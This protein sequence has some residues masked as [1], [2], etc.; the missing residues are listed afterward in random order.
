MLLEEILKIEDENVREFM[1]L[2]F[3]DMVNANNMFCT[4]DRNYRKIGP[5]FGL[6]AYYPKNQPVENNVWG[7]K[8]GRGTFISY[9]DKTLR[10]KRYMLHPYEIMSKN[11]NSNKVIVGHN[12]KGCLDDDFRELLKGEANAILRAQ[13]SEDLSF[14]PDKS[15]DA[16]IT[17]PPYYDNVMY[18][19]ISDFFYVWQ[20]LALQD[21]HEC[22]RGEYSPRSREIIKN[23]AQNK[24]DLFFIRGL[25]NVFKE[26][27]RVLK[28]DG[29][30]V[31]TFHHDRTKAWASTL[32]AILEAR[33]EVW[34]RFVI[35]AIYPVRSEGRSGVHSKGIRYDVIIVCR[36]TVEEPERISWEKLKDE[37]HERAR[38]VLERLWLSDRDLRDED[39]FVVAMGKC[40]EV[41]SWHYP[42]VFKDGK[43][44][45]VEEAVDGISDI[46]DSLLKIKEIEALPGKIDELTRLYCSYVVGFKE[47]SYDA[48]HKRLSKGGLDVD[49][50]F[51]ELLIRKEGNVIKVIDPSERRTFIEEKKRKGADLLTIDKVHMLYSVYLEGKPIVKYLPDYGGEDVRKVSELLYRKTG[52]EAYAKIAGIATSVP[53]KV[54]VPTLDEY[55]GE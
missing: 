39:M 9:V 46:I 14:I 11:G 32:R 4:Y 10:A 47:L 33:E 36:K 30:M 2:T 8:Y 20:K 41:Y 15:I 27:N 28:D 23:L 44:V 48:L 17:D 45:E 55:T 51:R 42:N 31:F 16:V 18:S 1:I 26:C 53:K 12:L 19:E 38:E 29:L 7:T 52:D 34:P 6:H 3:S 40:L 43:R 50:L 35:S 25:T 22:Y 5:L 24:D 54:K 13:T 37:I 21:K 49:L